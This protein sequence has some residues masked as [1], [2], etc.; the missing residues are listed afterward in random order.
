MRERLVLIWSFLDNGFPDTVPYLYYSPSMWSLYP[1]KTEHTYILC[2][3]QAEEF[4]QA[5]T[6]LTT[7]KLIDPLLKL[8]WCD[9]FKTEEGTIL[10]NW[11]C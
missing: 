5:M 9:E 8:H 10:L 6:D 2:W 7:R 3:C 4:F 1:H 11:C